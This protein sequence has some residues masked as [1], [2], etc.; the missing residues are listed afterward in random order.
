MQQEI[1]NHKDETMEEIKDMKSSVDQNK[2]DIAVTN[3][4]IE[5]IYSSIDVIHRELAAKAS[6]NISVDNPDPDPLAINDV[7]MAPLPLQIQQQTM[8]KEEQEKQQE[9]KTRYILDIAR[10]RVGLKP[11]T[12]EHISQQAKKQLNDTEINNPEN[13]NFRKMAALDFLEKELKV[14]D[15]T[16]IS[17]KLSSTSSILWIE[18][19][20]IETAEWI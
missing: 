17:S 2:K 4:K 16:I 9:N 6:T 1:N 11:V 13:H 3:N 14:K 5:D 20:N 10:K 8:S 15:A 12:P 19:Q 18:V 7:Y